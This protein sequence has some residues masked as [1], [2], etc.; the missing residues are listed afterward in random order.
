MRAC[1]PNCVSVCVLVV[2]AGEGGVVHDGCGCGGGHSN[3]S[4]SGELSELI[5]LYHL[6]AEVQNWAGLSTAQSR[7]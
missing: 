4:G 5:V 2:V 6:R 7:G 1:V 3:P